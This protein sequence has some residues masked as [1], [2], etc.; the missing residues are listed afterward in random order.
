MRTLD[1][2]LCVVPWVSCLWNLKNRRKF[3]PIFL[4]AYQNLMSFKNI[5]FNQTVLVLVHFIII[6]LFNSFSH[7]F[8][9]LSNLKSKMPSIRNRN[10]NTFWFI[11]QLLGLCVCWLFKDLHLKIKLEHF[12]QRILICMILVNFVVHNWVFAF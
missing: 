9:R 10:K 3:L 7:T 1:L 2:L 8:C 11:L 12:Q 5:D 6:I 4:T